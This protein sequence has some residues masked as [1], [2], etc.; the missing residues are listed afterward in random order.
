MSE[1]RAAGGEKKRARAERTLVTGAA[2]TVGGYVVEALLAEGQRVIAVDRPGVLQPGQWDPKRVEVR[3]GDLTD[4]GFCVDAVA[5]ADRVLHLAATI[6]LSLPEEA[7][8]RINVDAVRYLYEAARAAGCRRFVFFSS[9]SIYAQTGGPIPETAPIRPVSAYTRSKADAE[10]YLWSRPRA[11]MAV[12]VLRPSM[13]YGP[14]ARFLGARLACLPPLLAEIMPRI[15]VL[16]GG[17]RCNW[18]HAEDVARAAVFLATHPDAAWEAFNVA[19]E[20]VL[21]AGEVLRAVT[22]AYGLPLGPT[23]PFP[24]AGLVALGGWIGH[25]QRVLDSVS[26]VLEQ[27]WGAVCRRHGLKPEVF[28]G[29]D[30]EVFQFASAEAHFDT[31][32]IEAL[33]FRVKHP[34]LETSYPEVLR[35]FQAQRWLPSYEGV[36]R[37]LGGRT[38][39]RFAETMAGRWEGGGEARRSFEFTVEATASS[40]RQLGRDGRLALR[41][42][43]HA[44]GLADTVPCEGTLEISWLRERT[45]VYDLAFEG[46]D[47]RRYRFQG[48]KDVRLVR[49]LETMTTLPGRIVD[50]TG[51]PVGEAVAHFD[52]RRDLLSLVRSVALT[53][54]ASPV[55]LAS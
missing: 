37:E 15:P 45:L 19:D 16:E 48:R 27:A 11:G 53:P 2:G 14:R 33:G 9:G 35:W 42:T 44:A 54:P 47:G 52:A 20:T 40:L 26:G 3:E 49:L 25:R 32:K 4:L 36:S 55:A 51:G 39:L 28:P 21:T 22:E 12:T 38:G 43:L 31:A 30:Q 6:D 46:D 13:I 8:R 34:S 5:G 17:A 41:G 10:D 29:V 7:M 50:E 23:V 18:V 24:E 1:S